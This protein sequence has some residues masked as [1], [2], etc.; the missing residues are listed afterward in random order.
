MS[1]SPSDFEPQ[2]VSSD[3]RKKEEF[4]SYFG[5]KHPN[6]LDGGCRFRLLALNLK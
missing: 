3:L 5:K 1:V 2:I 4:A 6:N